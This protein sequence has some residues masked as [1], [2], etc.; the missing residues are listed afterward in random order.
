MSSRNDV[1][2]FVPDAQAT[3][4]PSDVKGEL[5][6]ST[7]TGSANALGDVTKPQEEIDVP[8]SGD[9]VPVVPG[10]GEVVPLVSVGGWVPLVEHAAN[11]S[12]SA[13]D[14]ERSKGMP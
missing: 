12:T 14:T 7:I 4:P 1:S 5:G 6:A 11:A 8:P 9:G 3:A 10:C 13:T 2:L